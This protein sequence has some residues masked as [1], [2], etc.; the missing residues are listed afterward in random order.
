MSIQ[1]LFSIG[2]HDDELLTY[3][4][5]LGMHLEAYS[6]LRHV[7]FDAPALKSAAE[8]HGKT[9]A[10]VRIALLY[11]TLSDSPPLLAAPPS[12]PV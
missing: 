9:P 12:Y 7:D 8:V 11:P 10:Q 2:M 6:P 3:T 1:V 5:K 4:Q